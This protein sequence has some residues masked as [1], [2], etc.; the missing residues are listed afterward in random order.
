MPKKACAICFVV[1]MLIIL[2]MREDQTGR[3]TYIYGNSQERLCSQGTG[4]YEGGGGSQ[5]THVVPGLPQ[6][7]ITQSS[8][9]AQLLY[10]I[11][12]INCDFWLL[13]LLSPLTQ[14]MQDP[15]LR[16]NWIS[17]FGLPTQLF[18]SISVLWRTLV[19]VSIKFL[20]SYLEMSS[21][22]RWCPEPPGSH[23]CH[24]CRPHSHHGLKARPKINLLA[25]SF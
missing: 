12:K 3:R 19:A 23:G 20:K 7:Y 1:L 11:L 9:G 2:G 5:N 24:V 10:N 15:F 18:F 17:T 21:V 13:F 16:G 6:C 14:S 22:E 8:N 25:V 4:V